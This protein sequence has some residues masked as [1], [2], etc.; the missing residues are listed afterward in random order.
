[1]LGSAMP[2]PRQRIDPRGVG[3]ELLVRFKSEAPG[4]QRE[5]MLAIKLTMEGA[6]NQQVADD[7][8]RT[9]ATIQT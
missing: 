1:M 7:L 6:A 8:G 2:I 9:L 3:S 4:W 5:R